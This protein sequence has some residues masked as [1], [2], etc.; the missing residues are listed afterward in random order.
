MHLP[1]EA[2]QTLAEKLLSRAAGRPVRAGEFAVCDVDQAMGT[3]ASVPMALDYF[4]AMQPKGDLPAPARPDAIAFAFDHYGAASGARALALQAIARDYAE[5]HGVHVFEVGDGIGHQRMMESGRVEPGRLVVAADSHAVSYGALNAFG[6]GIG[7]SDLAGVLQCQQVWLRV[8]QTCRVDLHGSLS[9]DASAKDAAL[10]LIGRLGADGASAMAIEFGGPGLAMLDMDDRIVLANMSVEAG[11]KA[12]I[13][14]FDALTAAWLDRHA[15]GH[16]EPMA[17]DPACRY[18][19]RLELDLAAVRPQLALPH[20]VDRVVD[21]GSAAPLAVDTVYLGTCTGGRAKDF[22]E[23]LEVLRG[24]RLATGVKLVVAPASAMVA[25]ALEADGSLAAFRALGA[26]IRRPGCAGCCG[27]DGPVPASGSRVLSTA[28][29]N[30]LGRMGNREA[31]IVLASPRTC[32]QAA[33][34]G[35][36]GDEAGVPLA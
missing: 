18:A 11:A 12:G 36:V 10:L 28:N 31:E 4:R 16:G 14:P 23:A 6:T 22:H 8:P 19:M 29:R 5:R 34:R 3:D 20:Q 15:A 13:F 1:A 35:R 9:P 17:A 33:L 21:A 26:D 27:T 32:A 2:A 30:F 7:S 25:A 24:G